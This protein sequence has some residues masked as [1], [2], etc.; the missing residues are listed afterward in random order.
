M[1]ANHENFYMDT[2]ATF[3]PIS[4]EQEIVTYKEPDFV[5]RSGSAYWYTT[6]G[7]IRY[8]NHWGDVG[9]CIWNPDDALFKA[10]WIQEEDENVDKEDEGVYGYCA[11]SD[12][13]EIQSEPVTPR[14]YDRPNPHGGPGER[15]GLSTP[16]PAS[17]EVL[18]ELEIVFSDAMSNL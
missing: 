5:S 4:D 12:F 2:L 11:W 16:T 1:A 6:D 7:V 14:H 3:S 13:E 15:R 8:S 17:K 18:R 9:S 10:I